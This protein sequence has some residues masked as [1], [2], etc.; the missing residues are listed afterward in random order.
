MAESAEAGDRDKGIDRV[1]IGR[2]GRGRRQRYGN[3]QE[4]A[5]A[6]SAEAGDRARR[7]EKKLSLAEL[8]QEGERGKGIDRVGNGGIGSGRRQR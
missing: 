7:K 1:G 6:E 4:S 8:A 2:I 5:P 3:R